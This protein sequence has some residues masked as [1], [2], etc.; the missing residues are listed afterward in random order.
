MKIADE[1]VW[2]AIEAGRAACRRKVLPT[3]EAELFAFTKGALEHHI[4]AVCNALAGSPELCVQTGD[5]WRCVC[6]RTDWRECPEC[7]VHERP[8]VMGVEP[9]KEPETW[10]QQAYDGPDVRVTYDKTG[11][12]TAHWPKLPPISPNAIVDTFLPVF[13]EDCPACAAQLRSD[14]K[15]GER[16]PG[17]GQP[18]ILV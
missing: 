1:Y 6:G 13:P 15:N 14:H 3:T 5:L 11:Y 10:G 7:T 17:C 18:V 9:A 2:L 4:G 16:C 12:A 8:V